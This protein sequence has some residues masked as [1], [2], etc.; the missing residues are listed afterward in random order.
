MQFGVEGLLSF[1]LTVLQ[2]LRYVYWSE[3][4]RNCIASLHVMSHL[5][6]T[7]G[8]GPQKG[9]HTLGTLF[10]LTHLHFTPAVLLKCELMNYEFEWG[11]NAHEL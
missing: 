8:Q 11:N 10:I 5:N 7:E 9:T 6:V 3:G 4:P 1:S 2:D